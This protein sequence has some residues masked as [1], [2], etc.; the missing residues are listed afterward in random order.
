[1]TSPKA[2]RGMSI[3]RRCEPPRASAA[4]SSRHTSGMT[5]I[6]TQ[7]TSVTRNVTD[8]HPTSQPQGTRAK[9]APSEQV[10]R[11]SPSQAK[12]Q[13]EDDTGAHNDHTIKRRRSSQHHAD[14]GA[15][16]PNAGVARRQFTS[17]IRHSSLPREGK[18]TLELGPGVYARVN[19]R[20]SGQSL[21]KQY[22]ELVGMD[23]KTDMAGLSLSWRGCRMNPKRPIASVSVA[24]PTSL[25]S[26]L[27]V[28]T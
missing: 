4:G 8:P 24:V 20:S 6:P 23:V 3:E 1:M 21:M 27:G 13:R 19:P 14:N 16:N 28:L 5:S 25:C 12:R 26:C 15:W 11:G 18:M 9:G 22:I 2:P 7:Q 17:P 10:S